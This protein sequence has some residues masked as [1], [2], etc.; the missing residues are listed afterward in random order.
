MNKNTKG[1]IA[2]LAVAAVTV[3]AVRLLFKS[4]R[5]YA[6]V[7]IKAGKAQNYVMLLSF[8]ENY[9]RAWAKAVKKGQDTFTVNGNSYNTTGGK[10]LS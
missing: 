5:A 2:V 4:K 7:I 6:S 1:I 10:K 3:V 8:D 9:L